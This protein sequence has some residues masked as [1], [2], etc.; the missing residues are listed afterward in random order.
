MEQIA[1]KAAG[2]IGRVNEQQVAG[3]MGL[4]STNHIGAIVPVVEALDRISQDLMAAKNPVAVA[5]G[6]TDDTGITNVLVVAA[7]VVQEG[8]RSVTPDDLEAAAQSLEAAVIRGSGVIEAGQFSNGQGQDKEQQVT[9]A[10]ANSST[11]GA[12]VLN[13]LG[14][15][16]EQGIGTTAAHNRIDAMEKPVAAV[17]KRQELEGVQAVHNSKSEEWAVLNRA[18]QSPRKV[19]TPVNNNQSNASKN[20]RVSNSFDALMNE[21][22]L[23]DEGTTVQQGNNQQPNSA[24]VSI[25]QASTNEL[26][27]S[28]D[29]QGA[30]SAIVVKRKTWAE[31][32]EEEEED[33][34]DS[35]EEDSDNEAAQFSATPPSKDEATKVQGKQVSNSTDSGPK[36]RGLSPNAP[37]FVPSKQ[38]QIVAAL[39]GVSSTIQADKEV[40]KSGQQ[41]ALSATVLSSMHNVDATGSSSAMAAKALISDQDRALLDTLDSPKP[42][43]CAYSNGSKMTSQ[44]MKVSVAKSHEPCSAKRM[45]RHEPL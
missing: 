20:V 3:G 45:K 6:S 30:T 2:Q 4:D 41:R 31:R 5:V 22:I 44:K 37:A 35:I 24:K 38:Q 29:Q 25:S 39:E 34:A 27:G 40:A 11:Q 23:N 19:N 32:V 36:R 13:A 17:H 33:Y 18:K 9:P 7:V 42:H 14:K 43:R 12:S 16:G 26:S 1:D 21:P 10:A 15:S 8:A 28:K